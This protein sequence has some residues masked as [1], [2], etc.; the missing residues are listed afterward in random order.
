[1]DSIW[2]IRVASNLPRTDSGQDNSMVRSGCAV[3]S[4]KFG[5]TFSG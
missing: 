2:L 3:L 5:T 1:L 4:H